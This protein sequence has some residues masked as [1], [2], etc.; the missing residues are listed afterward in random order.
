M[1]EATHHKTESCDFDQAKKTELANAASGTPKVSLID[2]QTPLLRRLFK[3]TALLEESP[4][5]FRVLI[6]IAL[7][8][9]PV[10]FCINIFHKIQPYDGYVSE[11]T[12]LYL[13]LIIIWS[14]YSVKTLMTTVYWAKL[15]KLVLVSADNEEKLFRRLRWVLRLVFVGVPITSV[16]MI[17]AWFIPICT[18]IDEQ[19]HFYNYIAQIVRSVLYVI[20]IPFWIL[21]CFTILLVYFLV[22]SMHVIEIEHYYTVVQKVLQATEVTPRPVNRNSN[23][24]EKK[25]NKNSP[26]LDKFRNERK[27]SNDIRTNKSHDPPGKSLHNS[28]SDSI[29]IKGSRESSR[30]SNPSET[31]VTPRSAN[32]QND[33]DGQ[34][35][36]D[37]LGQLRTFVD[38][39]IV[40]RIR[41][42]ESAEK[43]LETE[44]K[45]VHTS[46]DIRAASCDDESR[47]ETLEGYKG[48]PLIIAQ[49][50]IFLRKKDRLRFLVN[51]LEVLFINFIFIGLAL[52]YSGFSNFVHAISY[53]KDENDILSLVRYIFLVIFGMLMTNLVLYA[54]NLLT[55]Y[56]GLF[57]EWVNDLIIPEESLQKRW[58]ILNKVVTARMTFKILTFNVNPSHSL[59]FIFACYILIALSQWWQHG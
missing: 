39:K 15:F 1:T 54:T 12:L 45:K 53:P 41:S 59:V 49:E 22:I 5:I 37:G 6:P 11:I 10:L 21:V 17:I 51:R 13:T 46:D 40:A 9:I 20:T 44:E 50:K 56:W 26:T 48:I 2:T 23:L 43:H 3:A 52:T 35:I 58:I 7:F 34:P 18:T 31:A 42:F 4:V 28:G 57:I 33:A 25:H 30:I 32:V 14:Y 24:A 8:T 16:I 55:I 19:Q 29:S 47:E 36:S 38:N 27:S